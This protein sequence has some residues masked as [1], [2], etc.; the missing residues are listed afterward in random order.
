MS[1]TLIRKYRLT[2]MDE[3]SDGKL[4]KTHVP[5]IPK[6]AEFIYRTATR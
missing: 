1:A 3:P 5:E 2:S 6:W 4:A